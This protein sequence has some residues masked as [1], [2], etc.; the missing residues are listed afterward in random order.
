M[1]IQRSNEILKPIVH[2]PE[3]NYDQYKTPSLQQAELEANVANPQVKR[4][5]K[6]T[7]QE[8]Y[9]NLQQLVENTDYN[10]SYTL[11]NLAESK[12]YRLTMK[13][14]GDVVA[15]FPPDLAA[16]IANKAKHTQLGLVIDV[17]K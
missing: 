14:S 15:T 9:Q 1:I 13:H 7:I 5:V 8:V 2:P 16:A 10:V 4:M 11:G 6:Q 12:Q 3:H 17:S